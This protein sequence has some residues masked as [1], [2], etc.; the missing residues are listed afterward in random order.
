MLYFL[1]SFWDV[2]VDRSFWIS[3]QQ[4]EGTWFTGLIRRVIILI[5]L[6]KVFRLYG[7]DKK[8]ISRA[9]K[10]FPLLPSLFFLKMIQNA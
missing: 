1:S 3:Q 10:I 6:Q 2:Q 4:D 5:I 8:L 7:A 9:V